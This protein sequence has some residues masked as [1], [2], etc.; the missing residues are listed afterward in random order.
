MEDSTEIV[1]Q[2]SVEE[3]IV[4][5]QDISRKA[6]VITIAIGCIVIVGW[7]FNIASLKSILPGLVT[8]KANTADRKSVV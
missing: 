5:L 8:M 1:N 7:I 2:M 6:S 3:I 4:K